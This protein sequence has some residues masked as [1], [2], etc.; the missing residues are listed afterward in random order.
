[1]QLPRS[2]KTPEVIQDGVPT[3]EV[4]GTTYYINAGSLSSERAEEFLKLAPH[5]SVSM[6]LLDVHK[7]IM[8]IYTDLS[9]IQK[10]GDV[11]NI[12]N[13][14]GNILME[15]K[16]K[17]AGQLAKDQVEVVYRLC[18]LFCVKAGE[19]TTV[20]D[21]GL[22]EEKIAAWKRGVDFIS[23]FLLARQLSTMF[24]RPSKTDSPKT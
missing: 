2:I 23:F 5:L 13:R 7:L 18:A 16:D 12:T 21:D 10:L 11:I 19:D 1:M 9:N 6:E 20:I 17:S 15:T 24:K 22:M 8:N 14:V 4:E 3:F